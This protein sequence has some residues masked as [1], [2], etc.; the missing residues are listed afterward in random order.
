MRALIR[1]LQH[2]FDKRHMHH[3]V[4]T[5]L[6]PGYHD[7]D[8]MVLYANMAL[9]KWYLEKDAVIAG[10]DEDHEPFRE[11]LAWFERYKAMDDE[12]PTPTCSCA[13]VEPLRSCEHWAAWADANHDLTEK[14]EAEAEGRLVWMM[15][16]RRSMWS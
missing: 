6:A 11:M 15:R 13:P 9:V 10:T 4:H 1:W 2:R 12:L 14:Y 5:D 3:L 16:N 7:T 8:L